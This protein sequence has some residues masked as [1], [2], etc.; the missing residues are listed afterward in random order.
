M[1]YFP[2]P[3]TPNIVRNN[4]RNNQRR[5]DTAILK[6]NSN[7]SPNPGVPSS[8]NSSTTEQ[9]RTQRENDARRNR[10][11]MLIE[12]REFILKRRWTEPPKEGIA[13]PN[14]NNEPFRLFAATPAMGSPTADLTRSPSILGSGGVCTATGSPASVERTA[15]TTTKLTLEGSDLTLAGSPTA[16]G[17][18]GVCNATGST[19]SFEGTATTTG[20]T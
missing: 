13:R 16:L 5:E 1:E 3:Q 2:H 17:S 10:G 9:T 18:V 6:D 14:V 19:V 12:A 4:K 20:P 15:T 11:K 7:Q 8:Q